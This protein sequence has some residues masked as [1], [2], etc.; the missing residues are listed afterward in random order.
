MKV[1]LSPSIDRFKS[2]FGFRT[3]ARDDLVAWVR[4]ARPEQLAFGAEVKENNGGG[5]AKAAIRGGVIPDVVPESFRFGASP[6]SLAKPQVTVTA[7]VVPPRGWSAWRTG[8]FTVAGVGVSSTWPLVQTSWRQ[9][10]ADGLT[11]S[12]SLT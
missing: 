5:D 3:E 6:L 9:D 10:F 11:V 1:R 12:A 7:V 2:E 4:A 8:T